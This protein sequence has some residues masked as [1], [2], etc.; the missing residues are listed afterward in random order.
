MRQVIDDARLAGACVLLT[1]HELPE[2]ERLADRVVI[3]HHGHVV[4]DGTP[5]ELARSAGADRVVF[6]APAG[7]DLA[8]LSR[9]LGE[10]VEV[11]ESGRYLVRAAG[12]PELTARLANWLAEQHAELTELRTTRSLEETY[13]SL[14]EAA[15]SA[16]H[17][18][19]PPPVDG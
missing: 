10:G 4:A 12:S 7:L 1:T 3:V 9:A 5:S 16:G 17:D 11:L 14:V 2:A 8:S 19:P 6:S 15:D 18:E 13:L